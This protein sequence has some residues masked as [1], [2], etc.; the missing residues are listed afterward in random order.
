MRTDLRII[1]TNIKIPKAQV[2]TCIS[3]EMNTSLPHDGIEIVPFLSTDEVGTMH[4]RFMQEETRFP[5]YTHHASPYVL[6]GFGAYG[7]PSS[8]H[9]SF[10]KRLRYLALQ[11]IVK[12]GVFSRYIKNNRPRSQWSEYRLEVLVDRMMHR[13]PG[14][15]PDV[16]SA[17]RDVT[18]A[19]ELDADDIVFGGWVNLN[20]FPQYF[21]CKP[22]SHTDVP[23]IDDGE[24]F[25]TLSKVK[26]Q[27]EYQPFRE[28]FSVPS[29]N[30]LIFQ[31]NILHEVAKQVSSVDQ[32]RVFL[33]WRL[34]RGTRLLYQTD[35]FSAVNLLGVHK[36]PSGQTP[37]MYSANHASVF[38]NKA[39]R[40]KGGNETASLI[41]WLAQSFQP[42]VK[43]FFNEKGVF[44]K[45]TMMTLTDYGMHTPFKYNL[46]DS[47]VILT[48]HNII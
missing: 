32:V 28:R 45:R 6:G 4:T 35:K 12:N 48:L 38:K 1:N 18:P 7:N 13:H 14:Q 25:N 20:D 26:A 21:V 29:G 36:L 11:S 8:F 19:S 46:T 22:G 42:Y 44:P 39:F 3:H 16:E 30:I 24:G 40:L 31:Q 2:P 41:Q 33:G 9:N 47:N 15:T 17:H 10:V 23:N 27:V 5:E 34:T 43:S 37:P